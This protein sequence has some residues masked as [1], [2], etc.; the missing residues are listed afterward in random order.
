MFP[1]QGF[2]IAGILT[3]ASNNNMKSFQQFLI[4][5]SQQVQCDINGV[6][7][8][9]INYESAGNEEKILS[10]YKD[11][12]GL[13]TIGHGHLVTEKSPKIFA[14]LN[15]NPNILK[16]E[17]RMTPDEA[18]KVLHRDVT[19]RIPQV[20]K[21]VP[22]FNNYSSELQGEIASEQFRG[23]LGQ[24][25]KAVEKL[26]KGDYEGAATEYLN[27]KEYR[28]SVK[29]K[30]GIANRMQNLANAIRTE[31]ERQK[32]RQQSSQQ[33]TQAPQSPSTLQTQPSR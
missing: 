5:S 21:L 2:I 19:Q 23:M 9:L 13:D 16:G 8:K 15:I 20:Q 33:T 11:S 17:G 30:T 24:S 4:E 31:P 27:A 3:I 26:N 7:K 29:N 28:D 18:L 6:C 25:P 12:K 14:E 1:L 22:N 32:K 10:V